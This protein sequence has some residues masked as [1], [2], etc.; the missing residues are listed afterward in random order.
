MKRTDIFKRWLTGGCIFFTVFSVCLILLKLLLDGTAEGNISLLHFLL[1]FPCGLCVSAANQLSQ[2]SLSEGVRLLL[3]Y[4]ITTLSVFAFLWL[5]SDNAKDL[6]KNLLAFAVIT[7]LYWLIHLI[8][9]R[10]RN[11]K[12][13]H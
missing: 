4:L 1:L 9:R 13:E 12:K 2:T 6:V 5:P 3:H 10:F 7:L 11:R 8:S